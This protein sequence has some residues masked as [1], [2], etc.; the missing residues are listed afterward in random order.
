MP[1]EAVSGPKFFT[2][3]AYTDN[4]NEYRRSNYCKIAGTAVG[5]GTGAYAAFKTAKIGKEVLPLLESNGILDYVV[6]MIDNVMQSVKEEAAALTEAESKDLK[7]MVT[8]YS[9]KAFKGVSVAMFVGAALLGLGL[10]GIG[11]GI[12]NIVK[13]RNADKAAKVQDEPADVK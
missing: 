1:V 7:S 9:K 4:G 11:D 12:A 13:R 3:R 6:D 5:V 8:N 2:S 10:G